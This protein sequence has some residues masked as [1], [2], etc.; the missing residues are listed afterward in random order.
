MFGIVNTQINKYIH[1][2]E[3]EQEKIT[4]EAIPL[5]QAEPYEETNHFY[6][7]SVEFRRAYTTTVP[8]TSI[9]ILSKEAFIL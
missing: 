2:S 8:K 6:R 5:K 1:R 9:S 4:K 3:P 7:N